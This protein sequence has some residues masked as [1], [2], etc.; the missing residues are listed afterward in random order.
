VTTSLSARDPD[1]QPRSRER[2][3]HGR[4]ASRHAGQ[5][6]RGSR[7]P[8]RAGRTDRPA[9]WPGI[10]GDPQRATTDPDYA[11]AG[12]APN[13]VAPARFLSLRA[14]RLPR[15][16]GVSAVVRRGGRP[17]REP[18]WGMYGARGRPG[19]RSSPPAQRF[20]RLVRVI[21]LSR[22]RGHPMTPRSPKIAAVR[23]RP[24]I[25]RWQWTSSMPAGHRSVYYLVVALNMLVHQ[26]ATGRV[27]QAATQ[28][29]TMTRPR[30][31]RNASAPVEHRDFF[32][33]GASR[34]RLVR[35][36]APSCG[37]VLLRRLLLAS[38]PSTWSTTWRSRGDAH[39]PLKR[40]GPSLPG[41]CGLGVACPPP[42]WLPAGRCS[43]SAN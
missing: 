24:G 2:S 7:R 33:R 35:A 26:V 6:S 25:G 16:A 8:R 1:K 15:G 20:H 43:G 18:R 29:L 12:P 37:A 5:D 40:Q 39:H 31:S 13:M 17:R 9:C 38:S 23:R 41:G 42:G 4:S 14:P 34:R 32:V 22:V 30:S 36:A 28:V 3:A 21:T 11:G 27:C 19:L 10:F